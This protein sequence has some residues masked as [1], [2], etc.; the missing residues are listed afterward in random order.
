MKKKDLEY[1]DKQYKNVLQSKPVRKFWANR[2][3]ESKMKNKI[4]AASNE[5]LRFVAFAVIEFMFGYF[6]YT[7]FHGDFIGTALAVVTGF[8]AISRLKDTIN[9]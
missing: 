9:T 8:V 5:V 7:Y 4:N 2:R 3:K 1:I 6:G